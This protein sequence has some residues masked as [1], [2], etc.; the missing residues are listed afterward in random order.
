MLGGKAR[1]GPWALSVTVMPQL[2]GLPLTVSFLSPPVSISLLVSLLFLSSLAVS[3]SC[4][5]ALLRPQHP[6]GSEAMCPWYVSDRAPLPPLAPATL[7]P[8]SASYIPSPPPPAHPCFSGTPS[9][10][11]PPQGSPSAPEITP[12]FLS[13]SSQSLGTTQ[14]RQPSVTTGMPGTQPSL[15]LGVCL[16]DGVGQVAVWGASVSSSSSYS[17]W[18]PQLPVQPQVQLSVLWTCAPASPAPLSAAP[19]P[20]PILLQIL[21]LT[22][23]LPLLQAPGPAPGPATQVWMF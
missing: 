8:A 7:L 20:P 5:L 10:S 3:T 17:F 21:V 15:L 1:A 19:F 11:T 6:G 13:R 14:L 4:L 12:L 23:L 16:G 22:P 9:P 2:L 18:F